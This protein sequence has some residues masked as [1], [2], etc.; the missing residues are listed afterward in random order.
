[1][2]IAQEAKRPIQNTPEDAGHLSKKQELH[3]RMILLVDEY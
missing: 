1:M 3:R 2:Y